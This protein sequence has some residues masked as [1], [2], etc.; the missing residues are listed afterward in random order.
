MS[1]C[2]YKSLIYTATEYLNLCQYETR[3][4]VSLRIILKNNDTVFQWNDELWL[5]FS[6]LLI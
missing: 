6:S 5:N 3:V 1:G 4:S 2:E